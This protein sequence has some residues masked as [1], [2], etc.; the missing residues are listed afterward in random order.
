[1]TDNPYPTNWKEVRKET[2]REAARGLGLLIIGGALLAGL[3]SDSISARITAKPELSAT[4]TQEMT[5]CWD[6]V[7]GVYDLLREVSLD[8]AKWESYSP[9]IKT[10]LQSVFQERTEAKQRLEHSLAYARDE[11]AEIKRDPEVIAYNQKMNRYQIKRDKN[12]VI[13]S[14]SALGVAILGAGVRYF[15]RKK[16]AKR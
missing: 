14:S 16:G 12:A 15:G 11:L 10:N 7:E 3:K 9:V 6:Q 2:G 4:K 13:I 5:R 1:M 8:E